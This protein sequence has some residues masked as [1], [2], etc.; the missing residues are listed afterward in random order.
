[1]YNFRQSLAFQYR[2][3]GLEVILVSPPG[4]Y[5]P[6]L[7]KLGFRWIPLNFSTRSINPLKELVLLWTLFKLYCKEQPDLV[8]HFTI[9]CALYGTFI[10]RAIGGIKILNSITGLGHVFTDTRLRSRIISRFVTAL[11]RLILS[12]KNIKVTFQ[13]TEDRD[14]FVDHHLVKDDQISVIRGSGVDCKKFRPSKVVRVFSRP[15]RVLFASR[16]IKEKGV[17]E[18]VQAAKIL[19][20]RQVDVEFIFAG[21]IYPENPSSLTKEE[22]HDI[23]KSGLIT[24][25]G[26]VHDM[27]NLI[28]GVDMVVLPSYREGSPKILLE[29]AASGKP[30][31]ATDIAGCRGI[32]CPQ[33]NGILVPVKDIS[34]LADAI[35]ILAKNPA[36]R[37]AFGKNGRKLALQ[38]FD[39]R[40]INEALV[41]VVREFNLACPA[42]NGRII[43]ANVS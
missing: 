5:G 13:N 17:I 4:S 42:K 38:Q 21:D 9:K 12:N 37:I 36:M 6:E 41:N 28:A 31:V 8:H 2:K 27:P 7:E 32:V 30:I 35:E 10:A 40:I 25:L 11:Y 23:A 43:R 3:N 33:V 18:L 34:A 39:Q 1:M 26:H 29:A 15:V 24:Y 16:M 14:Y 20:Q 22:I 19:K